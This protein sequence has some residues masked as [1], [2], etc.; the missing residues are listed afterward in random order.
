M[1]IVN[2]HNDQSSYRCAHVNPKSDIIDKMQQWRDWTYLIRGQTVSSH[3]EWTMEQMNALRDGVELY[4]AEWD[5][6][7]QC[8]HSL[9]HRSEQELRQQ[10]LQMQFADTTFET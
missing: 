9:I 5:L 10:W 7:R 3:Q 8:S 1:S 6:V 2:D 4:G